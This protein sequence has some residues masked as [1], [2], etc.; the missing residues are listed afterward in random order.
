MASIQDAR[1]QMEKAVEATRREFATVRTG[2]ATPALLETIRVDA[3][4][5]KLP[6]NQVGT[7]S[8]P[9]PRTLLIQPWDKGLIPAIE[10]AIRAAEL[11]LNPVNDGN[12]IR[13]PVPPLTEE[14]RRE[15]VRVLHKLAEEGR[16]AVRHARQEANKEIKRRQQAHEISEDEARRQLDEVQKLT[17]Q[18][19]G[20]IDELLAAKEKEVMEV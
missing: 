14:R 19:I 7:V 17:D 6:I 13:I 8:V 15:M 20:K 4:G 1:A 12:V 16:V 5:S 2:K 9:E 3:Y 18:Y 10:K 11:G